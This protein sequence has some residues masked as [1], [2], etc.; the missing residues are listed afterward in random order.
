MGRH[1]AHLASQRDRETRRRVLDAAHAIVSSG[2]Y[3][4]AGVAAVAQRAGVATG[5]LYRHF[6]SKGDLL[7]EVFREA[8]AAEQRLIAAIA[9]DAART[10]SE[11]LALTVEAF[12]RR[13]LAAPTLAYALMAEPVDPAVEAARLESKR[14][15]RDV[16]ATLLQEGI[17]RRELPALDPPVVASALVGALPEALIGPLADHDSGDAL[18]ASLV[19]FALR[20]AGAREALREEIHGH[21]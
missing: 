2:G 16:F 13:A 17:D 9:T 10:V 18:V 11:R 1:P 20:C 15:Y 3:R 6:P 12:A 5:T 19:S 7:A 4:E 21:R 14:G 8:A